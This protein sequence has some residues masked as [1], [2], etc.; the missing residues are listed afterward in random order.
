MLKIIRSVL[1]FLFADDAVMPS[2]ELRM[3]QSEQE[4]RNVRS[5]WDQLNGRYY[6]IAHIVVEPQLY[7]S[8]V[9]F[10]ANTNIALE[11]KN[12]QQGY[13]IEDFFGRKIIASLIIQSTLGQPP[14]VS[15]EERDAFARK[16]EQKC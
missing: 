9:M 6:L 7:L 2:K 14:D 12:D 8:N 4:L 10:D 3:P 15:I 16:W 5:S 11:L 13:Q 1:R